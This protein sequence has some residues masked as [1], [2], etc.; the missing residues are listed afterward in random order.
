MHKINLKKHVQ[1]F[2]KI[3]INIKTISPQSLDLFMCDNQPD[4]DEQVPTLLVGT[5]NG[6]IFE[7][8]MK[9][10]YSKKEELQNKNSTTELDPVQLGT[11]SESSSED[12][13]EFDV[14][15][16]DKK[17][18]LKHEMIKDFRFEYT[19]HLSSHCA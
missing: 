4:S 1:L 8:A 3:H 9:I 2:Q 17:E 12:D 18:K 15:M 5:R 14:I 13:D 11:L 19:M 6:E 10:N 7:M 16:K